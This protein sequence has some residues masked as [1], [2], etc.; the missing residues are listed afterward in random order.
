MLIIEIVRVKL[1]YLSFRVPRI[2]RGLLSYIKSFYEVIYQCYRR[3]TISITAALL[4]LDKHS[5]VMNIAIIDILLIISWQ[6][7]DIY[8]QK[9]CN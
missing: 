9:L 5:L 3:H 4:K 1:S 6:I 8:F 2:R 7:S